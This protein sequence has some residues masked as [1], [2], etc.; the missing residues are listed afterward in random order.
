MMS[1]VTACRKEKLIRK[2]TLL[3]GEFLNTKFLM[4]TNSDLPFVAHNKVICADLNLYL[5]GLV[6]W[7]VSFL[8]LK[9]L[10]SCSH[11]G[12]WYLNF[13]TQSTAINSLYNYY[14]Y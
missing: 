8:G 4:T 13:T 12:Y 10:H 14:L 5:V 11:P 9:F 1:T 2:A 6:G 7:I 3:K